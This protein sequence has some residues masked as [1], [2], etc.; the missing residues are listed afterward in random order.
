MNLQGPCGVFELVHF[1]MVLNITSV[2]SVPSLYLRGLN[3]V[4]VDI[5]S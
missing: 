1:L 3:G 5:D 4:H 2:S